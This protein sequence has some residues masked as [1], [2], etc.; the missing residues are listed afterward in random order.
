M[1][2][3]TAEQIIGAVKER[4]PNTITQNDICNTQLFGMIIKYDTLY[5]S[6]SVVADLLITNVTNNGKLKIIVGG[7]VYDINFY[8]VNGVSGVHQ[9][10]V[11]VPV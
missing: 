9:I 7:K 8:P 1:K 11:S 2:L 5:V 10:I 6:E 4:L 3:E